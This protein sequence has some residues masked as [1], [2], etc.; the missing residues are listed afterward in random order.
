MVFEYGPRPSLKGSEC[1]PLGFCM[2]KTGH[3]INRMFVVV[4]EKEWGAGARKNILNPK[5]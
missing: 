4:L 1:G 3:S 2:V 5:P